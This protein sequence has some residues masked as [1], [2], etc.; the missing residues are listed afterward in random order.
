MVQTTTPPFVAGH[1]Y[2]W[3]QG[4]P[5]TQ[6]EQIP[7]E[8]KMYRFDAVDILFV[9][10]FIVTPIGEFSTGTA[11]NGKSL[12]ERFKWV[13]GYAREKNP[14]IRIIAMQWYGDGGDGNGF[15]ALEENNTQSIK[16]DP[17]AVTK[18]IKTYTDSVAKFFEEWH[19]KSITT[20]SGK[21]VPARI[22]GYD[23]DYEEHVVVPDVPTILSQLRSK[24][25]ALTVKI[26][27]ENKKHG[28][29]TPSQPFTISLSSATTSFLQSTAKSLDYINM[30]N[31]DG[32]RSTPPAHYMRD[33][34]G[35]QSHQLVYGMTSEMTMLNEYDN[36]TKSTLETVLQK[37]KAGY[38]DSKTPHG[39]AGVPFA[40]LMIWRLNS[41]N[42]IFENAVQVLVYNAVHN[43]QLP[44][45]PNLG[46]VNAVWQ[47]GGRDA[48]GNPSEKF[49]AWPWAVCP[50][51]ST[52]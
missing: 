42:R 50:A 39:H 5:S 6:W 23:I 29:T 24:L 31:Y 9:T 40:G 12:A 11:D 43:I 51:R 25:N 32:G 30:Q 35:L 33:I 18:Y 37:F 7:D 46:D 45:T 1:M 20:N 13:L 36:S 17:A 47:S 2:L 34:D 10:P 27:T 3:G 19:Y 48:Q 28:I 14:K 44:F 16:K 52:S 22:D 49:K 4:T 8:W 41:D 26:N 38:I 15:A 21:V